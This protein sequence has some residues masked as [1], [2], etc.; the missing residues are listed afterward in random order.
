[1]DSCIGSILLAYHLT[2]FNI[3]TAPIINY[4]R[5]SFKSHFETA[6][7]FDAHDL[8]FINEVDL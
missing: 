3:P 7:L 8:I 5:E 1:M 6:Q 2:L 4:N